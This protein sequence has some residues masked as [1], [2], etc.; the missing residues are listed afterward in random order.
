M[1]KILT[2]L[3]L[4]LTF[5]FIFANKVL[6]VC[7]LCTIAVGAGVGLSR[8]LGI[9]D[10]IT[11]LWIGGLIVSLIFWTDNWL[12]K[13]NIRFK[14]K[15]LVVIIIYYALVI[16]PLYTTGI[17]G[18]PF[19]TLCF[20]HLDKLLFGIIMGSI[21]F[22]CGSTWYFYM[23]EKNNGHAYFP[24]QKVVMPILPLVILSIIYYFLT[25]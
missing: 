11:G 17:I 22:W 24:F 12:E 20:C 5:G 1:R 2:F 10:S 23:K 6:A 25:K 15:A 7:P 3:F 4:F 16:I 21:A 9:D 14:G 19:N 13:K 18:Y 8:W